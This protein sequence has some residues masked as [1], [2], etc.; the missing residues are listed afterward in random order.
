MT[1][2]NLRDFYPW[3]THDEF[4]DVPDE[5]AEAMLE[6][7]RLD[8]NYIRRMFYNKAH[9][10]LD[11]GDGIEDEVCFSASSFHEAVEH[12]ELMCR[13]C[14]ALNSLPE[15]QGRRIEAHYILG[16][17]KVEIA[18]AEGVRESAVRE[19]IDRGLENMK[20]FLKKT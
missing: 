2:I 3:Y 15:I 16:K 1:T 14:L 4:L 20:R 11:A 5:V 13:L 7:E 8:R 19:S 18:K 10:S 12:G 6:A 17:S 9:F